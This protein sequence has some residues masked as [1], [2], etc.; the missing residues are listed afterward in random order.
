MHKNSRQLWLGMVETLPLVIAAFP[1]GIVFG[2]LAQ[3]TGLG[4]AVTLGMSAIVFA[5]AS[6]FIAITLLAAATAFPVIVL[7]VFVVNL[8]Q[9]L[10]S[11]NLMHQ[12]EH[13]PQRCRGWPRF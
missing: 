5:G 2:A 7:T 3:S 12:V 11:A 13:W 4:F 10:Y 8:R 1:F 6:Q 9:M